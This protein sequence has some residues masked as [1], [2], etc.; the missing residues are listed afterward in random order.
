MNITRSDMYCLFEEIDNCYDNIH[1]GD[2]VEAYNNGVQSVAE[3]IRRYL[4]N[5]KL[6]DNDK[7]IEFTPESQ[8]TEEKNY[9]VS[10]NPDYL[11]PD[12]ECVD[13]LTWHNGKWCYIEVGEKPSG[14]AYLYFEDF[15]VPIDAWQPMPKRYIKPQKEE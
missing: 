1:D 11:P 13:V 6:Y 15:D 10:V 9:L 2:V 4:V 5:N 8:P 14:Y 12:C 7:W 3:I